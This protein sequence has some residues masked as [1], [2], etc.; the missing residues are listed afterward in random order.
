M[1]DLNDDQQAAASANAEGAI[2]INAGAGTGKTKTLCCRVNHLYSQH[3]GKIL[4]LAFNRSVAE[5]LPAKIKKDVNAYAANLTKV[6]TT[7]GLAYK[8]VRGN[9]RSLGF[10]AFPSVPEEW[11]VVKSAMEEV[12]SAGLRLTEPNVKSLLAAE[13]WRVGAGHATYAGFAEQ[14]RAM[15]A[16]LQR[17]EMKK[18]LELS[19]RF[20]KRRLQENWV[21]FS[22]M[23]SLALKLPATIFEN[24]GYDHILVDEAQ[25]LNAAQHELIE[26]LARHAKSLTMVGDLAQAIYQFS[27][28]RPDLFASIPQRYAAKDYQLEVNYRC[29]QPILDLANQLLGLPQIESQ[30]RLKAPFEKPG[31]PVVHYTQSKDVITWLKGLVDEDG[32]KPSDIAVIFRARK[33]TLELENLVSRAGLSYYSTAGSF[34]EHPVLQDI[35][36]Y[37]HLLLDNPPVSKHWEIV[38]RHQRFLAKDVYKGAWEQNPLQ[39]WQVAGSVLTSGKGQ[40]RS[41]DELTHRLKELY[42]RLDTTPPQRVAY[43]LCA[44]VLSDLWYERTSADPEMEREYE[45]MQR[46]VLE[47][48]ADYH[49][50]TE[51]LH[52]ISNR[53]KPDK[54]GVQIISAHK[55]KGLEWPYVAIWACGDTG[56]PRSYDAEEIRLCY[57]AVTRAEHQ[58]VL[59]SHKNDPSGGLLG[60]LCPDPLGGFGQLFRS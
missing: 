46:Y 38:A 7:Y 12:R 2:R 56:F 8:L 24:L 16:V 15:E 27:G 32:V 29:D 19:Q 17:I 44:E 45:E 18:A 23:L 28:A 21:V 36:A 58:L 49:T 30:L 40:L 55:A 50:G 43:E 59:V 1:S 47:M 51:L 4:V 34:F 39:P 26:N 5:E 48:F 60:S 37:Y 33:D 41:W 54:A 42:P 3:P 6:D 31:R 9:F 20:A 22:D 57:V 10:T 52:A 13:A 35:L 14:S 25:D 53:P 11:R